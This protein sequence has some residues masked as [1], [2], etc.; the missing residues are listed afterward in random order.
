[1]PTDL[2]V[3]CGSP[4]QGNYTVHASPEMEG[5]E[6]PL[7]DRCGGDEYP[8]LK[9]I[10]HAIGLKY[11]LSWADDEEP[12][13]VVCTATPACVL[14]WCALVNTTTRILWRCLYCHRHITIPHFDELAETLSLKVPEDV[15]PPRPPRLSICRPHAPWNF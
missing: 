9:D 14:S 4:A 3:F 10:W 15:A 2:C 5:P 1:M 11:R 8:L 7:C 12:S 6:L 13:H